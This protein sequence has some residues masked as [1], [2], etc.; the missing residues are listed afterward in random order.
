MKSHVSMEQRVCPVCGVA[1]D[2]GS[3]LLDK[4]LKQS[5]ERK[6]TTGWSFCPEHQA[7]REEGYVALV[8]VDEAKSTRRPDGNFDP[9]D[10]WRT[11]QIVHVRR[12]VA[13]RLFDV[14]V[15]DLAYCGGEV[16]QRLIA[17]AHPDDRP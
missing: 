17:M 2:T 15:G 16:V 13:D 6:T 14:P 12:A 8:E 11:G 7:R 4:R 3:I 5:M 1:F 9:G 10:V